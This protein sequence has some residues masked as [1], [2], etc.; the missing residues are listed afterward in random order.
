MFSF[1]N[2]FNTKKG[3]INYAI[4]K[5]SDKE[6][7]ISFMPA[8][9]RDYGFYEHD[10][11]DER[12]V[13]IKENKC[14]INRD[15]EKEFSI[16]QWIKKDGDFVEQGEI[17]N[18]IRYVPYTNCHGYLRV[19]VLPPLKSPETG[20]L[21]IIKQEDEE[22]FDGMEICKITC[23]EKPTDLYPPDETVSNFFFNKYDIPIHIRVPKNIRGEFDQLIWYFES[24]K[25]HLLDW[26]V[27]DK[28]F[29]NIGDPIAQV[30]A[31]YERKPIYK[32]TLKSKVSGFIHK[33]TPDYYSKPIYQD[34]LLCCFFKHQKI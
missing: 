34:S 8:F 27:D 31:I 22:V 15:S 3:N 2:L 26:L 18:L 24:D 19:A 29:V 23:A 1:K 7:K 14:V 16:Y 33:Y 12:G 11:F 5:I 21:N 13:L 25:I 30:G 6:L 17:I 20:Y 10:I 32:F 4:E 28:A 9:I